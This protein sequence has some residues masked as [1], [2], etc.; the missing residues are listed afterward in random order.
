[1]RA[2]AIRTGS[3]REL[4]DHA[5]MVPKENRRRNLPNTIDMEQRGYGGRV[6]IRNLTDG[7]TGALAERMDRRGKISLE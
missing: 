1:M 7:Q 3:D 2:M 6:V 4:Q 5:T